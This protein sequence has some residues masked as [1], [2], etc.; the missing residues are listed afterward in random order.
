MKN[1]NKITVSLIAFGQSSSL[2]F[3]RWP[4]PAMN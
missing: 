3:L 4:E 2:V 1:I